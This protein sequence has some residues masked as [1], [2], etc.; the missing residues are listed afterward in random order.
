MCILPVT[1][2]ARPSR[3]RS[4]PVLVWLLGLAINSMT[5]PAHAAARV[6]EVTG[7]LDVQDALIYEL[8][9]L[10]KGETLYIY[11]EGTSGNLDPSVGVLQPTVD[12]GTAR[13]Q[14]RKERDIILA[15]QP[16]SPQE[17]ALL[18]EKYFLDWD[19]DSGAGYAARLKLVIPADGD[20]RIVLGSSPLRPSFGDYRLLLGL[21]APQVLGD[22]AASTGDILARL[23]QAVWQGERRVQELSGTVLPGQESTTVELQRIFSGETLS[24]VLETTPGAAAPGLV[25]YDY[26]DKPLAAVPAGAH[27]GRVTLQFTF[28]EKDESPRLKIKRPPETE[29]TAID[30][31]LRAGVNAADVLTGQAAPTGKPIVRAV[32]PVEIGLRMDQI[33]GVDQRSENF[34]VVASLL[35]KWQD[36]MLAFDPQ[37]CKCRMKIFNG[38]AFAQFVQSRDTD[39]PDY[40]LFNQ[41]GNRWSQ[42]RLATVYPDGQVSY[43]ERFGV[44]LQAPDFKF[45]KFPFDDQ[46]FAIRID[47]VEPAWDYTFRELDGFSE[48]GTRLGEEQWLLTGFDSQ[49][50]TETDITDF[51]TSRF[52]FRFHA[53]RH[54]DYYIYRLFLPIL[55]IVIVSWFGFFLRDYG[56]RVDVAGANLLLFIAFNFTIGNDLPR[57]GYLTFLDTFLVTAFVITSLVFLLAVYM[58]RMEADGKQELAHRIDAHVMWL[59][60]VAYLLG[61]ALTLWIYA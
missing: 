20:Y 11:A 22:E 59:Y 15:D 9:G 28:E 5:A 54:L 3:S 25:L 56:K 27:N 16:E 45:R 57:L 52:T 43:L 4:L 12:V 60:P 58:K 55:I 31:H 6:Q 37:S 53:M 34:G 21:D 40:V 2:A 42:K 29:D 10:S 7:H 8:S 19:D 61:T 48:V 39:W 26:G 35:L 46:T 13:E 38:D 41:Q 18:F 33:T 47:L 1:I 49:I 14:F 36:P 30:F 50:T 24:A 17:F 23:R 51:P 32:T 44:T